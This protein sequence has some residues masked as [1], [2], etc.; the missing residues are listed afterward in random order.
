MAKREREKEREVTQMSWAERKFLFREQANL[1]ILV[2][3]HRQ[4]VTM[5]RLQLTELEKKQLIP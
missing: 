3:F 2:F 4:T 5:L 1:I